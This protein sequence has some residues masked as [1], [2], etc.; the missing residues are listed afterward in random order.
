MTNPELPNDTSATPAVAR[1]RPGAEP[2]ASLDRLREENEQLGLALRRCQDQLHL[3]FTLADQLANPQDPDAL[4]SVLLRRY[5]AMLQADAVYLDRAGCCMR[6][7]TGASSAKRLELAPDRLRGVLAQSVE[8]VRHDRRSLVPNLTAEEDA[9]LNG[10]RVLLGTLPRGD[11]ETG[12]VVA[13][14]DS[15]AAPFEDGDVQAS[16][17][18]LTYG[19]QVLSQVLTVRH[20]QRTA[21]ETVCTLVNAIDAKDNYTSAHS[22][23][24]GG[25]ARL[26]GEALALS[27]EKV[28]ALEWSG[29][30][31]DVGKIGV[32]EQILSKP[33]ALTPA[34]F[35][36]MKKH[37]QM[38]YDVL[39]PVAQFQPMLDAVL[40][41]HENCDGSG[42]PAGLTGEEIPLDA[43]I[44]HV[45][46][47]FDALTTNRPYRRAYDID[48]ALQ[49]LAAGAGRATDPAVTQSFID[50]LRRY[51][52]EHPADFRARFGHM[53]E[54]EATVTGVN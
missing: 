31:H 7:P 32:P 41:H 22:E 51:M 45:V 20:L 10:A 36:E 16:E 46:D 13:L 21:L 38:G 26:T 8:R 35:D 24:V 17:S 4:Q 28:Q 44:V 19:A 49:V 43:R 37:S 50:T 47:I 5:G 1:D 40:Y 54:A 33:G 25:L 2:L 11:C 15:S 27:K 3:V 42:Y 34:E 14:R 6:I 9:R 53:S 30:L 39:K 23:R 12:V 29:L 48:L 52:A 18:I